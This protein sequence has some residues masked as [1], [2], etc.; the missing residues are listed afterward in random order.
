[1]NLLSLEFRTGSFVFFHRLNCTRQFEF[2]AG[3]EVLD[4][5]P[6]VI[7][8]WERLSADVGLATRATDNGR[9]HPAEQQPGRVLGEA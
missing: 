1:M 4:I 8:R 2:W 6:Q 5:V 7:R 9:Q 3:R